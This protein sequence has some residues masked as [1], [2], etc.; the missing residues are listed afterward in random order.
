MA[1]K[2]PQGGVRRDQFMVLVDGQHVT[3]FEIVI[4]VFRDHG[5][6]P[7]SALSAEAQANLE[8]TETGVF[9][10]SY[11]VAGIE[12]G[13]HLLDEIRLRILSADESRVW[14]QLDCIVEGVLDLS[15]ALDAPNTITINMAGKC[16]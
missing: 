10:Y 4:R 3:P 7:D 12:A 13:V 8:E 2:A 14:H 16:C 6:T 9:R 5:S 1:V 15:S 11:S